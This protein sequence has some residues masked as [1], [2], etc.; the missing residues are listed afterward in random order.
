MS[1]D[2]IA[3]T[4]Q[5]ADGEP[6]RGVGDKFVVH[7]AGIFPVL[8]EGALRATLGILDRTVPRLSG[9]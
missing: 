5:G 7:M 6:V 4:L 9:G 1:S 2:R 3:P 8:S